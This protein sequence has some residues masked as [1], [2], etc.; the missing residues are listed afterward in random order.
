MTFLEKIK[1][2]Y[3]LIQSSKIYDNLVVGLTP[4]SSSSAPHFYA[5]LSRTVRGY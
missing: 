2:Y 4:S 5:T 1:N 3:H